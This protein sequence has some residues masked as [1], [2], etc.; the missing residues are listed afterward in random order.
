MCERLGEL[1]PWV[2]LHYVY[3][4]PHVDDLIPL[5]AEG[6]LLPYL[7]VPLQH[8]APGVLR[9]MRRPAASERTLERIRRWREA[10]PELTL[11]STFI[12]GFP[13]ETEEDFETLLGFLR[14]ARLERVGCFAYSDVEGARA[15]ALPDQ[16]PETV[17]HQRLDALMGLQA[18]ISLERQRARIGDTVEVLVDEATA[19]GGVG[20]T[21]GDAPEVD[22][23][24]HIEGPV[25]AGEWASVRVTGADTYDLFG[26]RLA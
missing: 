15:N 25:G 21:A 3:P 14:E 6:R 7:D 18:E 5:M 2:R 12:V 13:G 22:G 10:V 17:K 8:A 26:E 19:A 11:R 1:V 9:A 4:Y 16:V 24:V 20:R 23:V